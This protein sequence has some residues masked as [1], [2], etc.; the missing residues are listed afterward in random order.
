MPSSSSIRKS[1]EA[2]EEYSSDEATK[3]NEDSS[4]IACHEI[5]T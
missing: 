4:K 1:L 3:G 5:I 2:L